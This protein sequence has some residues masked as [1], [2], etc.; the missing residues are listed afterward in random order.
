M[1][2]TVCELRNEPENLNQDWHKLIDHI[3]SEGS[4][5]VLLPEMPFYPWIVRTNQIDVDRWRASVEAHDHWISRLSELGVGLVAGTRPIIKGQEKYNQGFLWQDDTGYQGVHDKY[6]L[7]NE[8][9]WWE[10]S[11]YNRGKGDFSVIDT[12]IVRIGFLICTELWFSA[13]AREYAKQDIELLVTPRATGKAS[14]DK[15]VV[16]G[17]AAAVVSGAYSLSS[18][19][20][21]GDEGD[22]TWG[23]NGWIIEPEN[24][25]VLGLTSH[26]KPYLTMDVD[27]D[28]ARK[29]KKSYPRNIID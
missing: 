2:V 15:W 27:L 13:H 16:G 19:F 7:P 6:Y 4:E 12:N 3:K 17:R 5:F 23:G 11:W 29:A 28:L 21:Y 8:A 20:R 18:N 25:E 1:R 14:V 10:A 9:G 24:G 26:D 22:M